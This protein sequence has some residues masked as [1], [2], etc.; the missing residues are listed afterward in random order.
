MK[1]NAK[2]M[3]TKRRKIITRT[4]FFAPFHTLLPHTQQQIN[5]SL[6]HNNKQSLIIRKNVC[7]IRH[8]IKSSPDLFKLINQT[9]CIFI[10]TIFMLHCVK[11]CSFFIAWIDMQ[12]YTE[13]FCVCDNF[14]TLNM[15]TRTRKCKWKDITRNC[16]ETKL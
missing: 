13:N 15:C 7:M 14:A 2:M 4:A 10:S 6:H 5:D 9:T 12:K 3:N 1:N 16:F 11:S 8:D